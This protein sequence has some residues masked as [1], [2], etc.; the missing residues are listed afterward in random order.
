MARIKMTL[1]G[2]YAYMPTIFDNLSV[3]DGMDRDRLQLELLEQ[4]GEFGLLYPDGDFLQ[5]M[6]GVWSTNELPIWEKLYETTQLE[7]NPIDNYDRTETIT[8]NVH[9]SGSGQ[10]IEKGTAFNELQPREMGRSDSTSSSS[11]GETVTTRARGNIGVT[12]SQQMIEAQ[13]EVVQFNVY[14]YIVRS[15]I[16]RFCIE[17][18]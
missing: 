13:R 5:M 14:S 1:V 6:I 10:S 4:A 2:L 18:Y 12:T 17:L 3:P 11:G 8:R 16:D 15:F 7:Y 9:S